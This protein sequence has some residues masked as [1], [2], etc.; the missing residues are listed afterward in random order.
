VEEVLIELSARVGV[1]VFVMMILGSMHAGFASA[2]TEPVYVPTASID[3]LEYPSHVVVDEHFEVTVSMHYWMPS[4]RSIHLE[5]VAP[6]SH[7]MPLDWDSSQ[8]TQRL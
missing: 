2:F 5:I 7:D 3:R 1:L 6:T 8:A 4:G